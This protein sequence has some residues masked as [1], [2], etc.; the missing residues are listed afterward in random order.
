MVGFGSMLLAAHRGLYTFGLVLTIGVG[1]CVFVSLIPLPAILTLLDRRR[2]ATLINHH[3]LAH[4]PMDSLTG[5][6]SATNGHV[7]VTV[8]PTA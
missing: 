7:H 8:V 1:S 4:T 6:P 5:S 2:R 3:N